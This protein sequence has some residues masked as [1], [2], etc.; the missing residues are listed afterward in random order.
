MKIRIVLITIM[1]AFGVYG[2]TTIGENENAVIIPEG[3]GYNVG[4]TAPDMQLVS[5]TGERM[6][7][8]DYR[9]KM[10]LIDFWASWCGPCRKANPHVVE[11]YHK[12]KDSK[13]KNAEGFVVWG[14]SL[15]GG[16]RGNEDSW[17]QAVKADKLSW[18]TN[19]LGN[20][21]IA[22]QYGIRSIPAQFLVDGNGIIV[23]SYVGYNPNENF[24]SKLK[25]LLK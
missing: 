14:I 13:F 12:Y 23:A 10:V 11:A 2:F 22:G 15:D 1:I 5:I 8:S 6:K 18:D 21:D 19:F 17:K 16:R 20:N 9:G 3:K 25:S 7:L 4:Q 24:E